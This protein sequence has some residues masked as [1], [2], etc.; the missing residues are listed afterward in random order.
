M[1]Q[2]DWK[3]HFRVEIVCPAFVKA[4]QPFEIAVKSI[5]TSGEDLVRFTSSTF[6]GEGCPV[7]VIGPGGEKLFDGRTIATLDL[8]E[9][10]VP[11]GAEIA[12]VW[13]FDGTYCPDS[14]RFGERRRAPKGRYEV[15]A[16]NGEVFRDALEIG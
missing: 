8:R 11:A 12:R 2:I 14:D 4:G 9:E 16:A 6:L 1:K 13:K 3:A 10:V 15:R 5:N 7:E